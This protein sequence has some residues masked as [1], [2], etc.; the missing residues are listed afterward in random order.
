MHPDWPYQ[1]L[2]Y[3]IVIFTGFL[4]FSSIVFP[5]MYN[6][7]QKPEP[8]EDKVFE[9]SSHANDDVPKDSVKEEEAAKDDAEVNVDKT[10]AADN[11]EVMEQA[12]INEGEEV[13][14]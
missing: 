7:L 3:L 2:G 5:Q 12:V 4:F 10:E 11:A 9:A 14:A 6:A 8:Q 1:I 13:V